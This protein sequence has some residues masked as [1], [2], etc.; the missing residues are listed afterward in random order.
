M[1]ERAQGQ[2]VP[3]LHQQAFEPGMRRGGGQGVILQVVENMDRV[4]RDHPVRQH[5]AQEDHM[6]D[7]VHRQP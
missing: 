4:R 7:R 5:R 1:V 3:V 6:L 2:T